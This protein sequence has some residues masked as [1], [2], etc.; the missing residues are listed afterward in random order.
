VD[1]PALEAENDAK[2]QAQREQS[3]ARAEAELT[4]G[5]GAPDA[6]SAGFT[7]AAE[8]RRQRKEQA[9]AAKERQKARKTAQLEKLTRKHEQ[10]LISDEEFAAKKANLQRGN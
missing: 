5:A 1:V 7:S 6:E 2:A 4:G 10:G 9:R 3:V 8:D